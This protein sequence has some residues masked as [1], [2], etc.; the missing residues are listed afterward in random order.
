MYEVV[1]E[2]INLTEFGGL[3]EGRSPPKC[4]PLKWNFELL[5]IE[6]W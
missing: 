1:Y 4:L 2:T 5:N 6:S 3:P